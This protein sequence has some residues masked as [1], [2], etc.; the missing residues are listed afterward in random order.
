M[1]IA[2][3]NLQP[4]KSRNF[5]FSIGYQAS[6]NVFLESIIFYNHLTDMIVSNVP[7]GD[8]DNDGAIETQNQNFGEADLYGIEFRNQFSV[9]NNLKLFLH[10]GLQDTEATQENNS[11]LQDQSVP[12]TA[13]IKSNFGIKWR[14]SENSSF[15]SSGRYIGK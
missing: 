8:I 10:L 7:I 12:N 15:Y 4:E 5:E 13:K 14:Y 2:N 3:P 1:R 9:G 6:E 11:P